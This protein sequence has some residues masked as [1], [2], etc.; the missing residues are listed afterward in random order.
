MVNRRPTR[1]TTKQTKPRRGRAATAGKPA[2]ERI[3]RRAY[4]LY[5]ARGDG[6]GSPDGD[7]LRAEREL[8]A[9]ASK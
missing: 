6:P 3:Q 8:S 1:S 5:L 4:E 2:R 9:A 7:W